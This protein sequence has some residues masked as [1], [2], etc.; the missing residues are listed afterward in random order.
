MAGPFWMNREL[1]TKHDLCWPNQRLPMPWG[2]FG[3]ALQSSLFSF[4]H[5]SSQLRRCKLFAW[6]HFASGSNSQTNR[7]QNVQFQSK[8]VN[9]VKAPVGGNLYYK[10]VP[11]IKVTLRN[12]LAKLNPTTIG[13]PNLTLN[14]HSKKT[15]L[16]YFMH[17]QLQVYSIRN[18]FENW[19]EELFSKLWNSNWK[20]REKPT[21]KS[22]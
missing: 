5:F 19:W 16:I 13:H 4:H 18:H 6:V 1:K 14:V 8:T 21:N 20:W 2:R 12:L 15:C 7:I 9:D 17:I 3:E 10:S 11:V 22:W